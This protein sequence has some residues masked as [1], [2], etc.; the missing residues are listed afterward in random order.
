MG[1]MDKI[2]YKFQKVMFDQIFKKVFNHYDK[3]DSGFIEPNE[4]GGFLTQALKHSGV[5]R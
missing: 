3:D 5:E 2:K 1:F 4:L